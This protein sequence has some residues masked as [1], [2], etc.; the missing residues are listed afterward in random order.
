MDWAGANDSTC[1]SKFFVFTGA[2]P[3]DILRMSA[4][5]ERPASSS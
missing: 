3:L 2:E 5:F 4:T 1:R